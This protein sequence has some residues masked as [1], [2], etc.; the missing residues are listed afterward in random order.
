MEM[1]MERERENSS[2]L[3]DLQTGYLH[4]RYDVWEKSDHVVVAH[5]HICD[6]L[7]QR[8]LLCRVVLVLLPAAVQLLTQF[9][10]FA[11]WKPLM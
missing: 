1:E 9:C 8:D 11:L 10:Y 6:D 2:H 3:L 5:S 4:A 7:L